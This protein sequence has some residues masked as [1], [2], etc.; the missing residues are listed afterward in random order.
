MEQTLEE[1]RKDKDEAFKDAA[2]SPL[3]DEQKV[4]FRGLSYFSESPKLVF[5][6][7]EIDPEGAGQP[8]EIPTS[9]GDTEQYLRA[10]IIKFSLEGKDYQLHLYHD[11]DGSEYFLPIKDATSGKETYVEG[12]YVDVEVENGQ[13]KRLDFNYA[14]NPYCAYNHNWRC[15]IAPEENM[16]PIAIEAGEKNF[17]G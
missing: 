9:A 12:R 6:S 3:T 17:N 16:L 1:F 8:V 10:G 11:L 15:P 2:W 5:Q 13:I 14:Y 4:N 7:M